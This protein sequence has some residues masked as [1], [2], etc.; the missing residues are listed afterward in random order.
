ML[1]K[2]EILMYQL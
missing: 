1:A 2:F